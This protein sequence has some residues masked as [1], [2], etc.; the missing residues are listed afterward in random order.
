MEKHRLSLENPLNQWATS[1]RSFLM[2]TAQGRPEPHTVT[3]SP[4]QTKPLGES[5]GDFFSSFTQRNI[6]HIYNLRI[7]AVPS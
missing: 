2:V 4:I 5:H 7:E 3:L 6:L 1:F